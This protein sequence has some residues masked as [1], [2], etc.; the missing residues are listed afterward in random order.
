MTTFDIVAE[1]LHFLMVSN[2]DK[3]ASMHR[4]RTAR[5]LGLLIR[6]SRADAGITQANLAT[7]ANVGRQWLSA[8]EAGHHD[9]AE[10]GMVLAV[11]TALEIRLFADTERPSEPPPAGAAERSVDSA[12]PD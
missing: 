2:G 9:R 12:P 5:E 11:L 1:R 6:Q 10:I 8:V 7:R 4:F 3:G